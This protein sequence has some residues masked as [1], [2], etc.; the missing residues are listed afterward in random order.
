[1]VYKMLNGLANSILGDFV[2][3]HSTVSDLLDHHPLVTVLFPFV[4]LLL[5]YGLSQ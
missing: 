5:D 1:M 4:T 2:H 3:F